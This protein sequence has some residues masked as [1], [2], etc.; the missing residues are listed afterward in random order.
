MMLMLTS[1]PDCGEPA[2]VLDRFVLPSTDGPVEHLRT[3]CVLRHSFL[4]PVT[5]V[6]RNSD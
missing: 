3:Y 5:E 1:C 4:A 6:R 2:E